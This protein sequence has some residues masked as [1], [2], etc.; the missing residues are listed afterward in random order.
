MKRV[1]RITCF[2]CLST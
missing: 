1:K 2:I